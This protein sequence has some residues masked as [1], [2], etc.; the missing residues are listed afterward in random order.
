MQITPNFA[1]LLPQCSVENLM[2]FS[3]THTLTRNIT[4]A[5]LVLHL[6]VT[7]DGNFN[8]NLKNIYRKHV[9]AVDIISPF[10]AVFALNYVSLSVAKS[11]KQL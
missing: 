4:P 1:S 8:F 9:A 11:L 6:G 7:F 10:F 2:V 3:P 5:T